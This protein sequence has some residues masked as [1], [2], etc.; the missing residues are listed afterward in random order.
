MPP[1]ACPYAMRDA[2]RNPRGRLLP[3]P[4]ACKK[5][6]PPKFP[7]WA[8]RVIGN[9]ETIKPT[10]IPPSDAGAASGGGSL[11]PRAR[12]AANLA[13]AAAAAAP[14]SPPMSYVGPA[15]SSAGLR[16]GSNVTELP[17][18][19]HGDA[20]PRPESLRFGG[21]ARGAA[22]AQQEEK[23]PLDRPSFHVAP[24]G[25]GWL[26]GAQCVSLPSV[27]FTF[28]DGGSTWDY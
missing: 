28:K 14:A 19:G 22:P 9:P 10:A 15:Q 7:R 8:C 5:P 12:S 13:T 23:T 1:G 24:R 4:L 25:G 3:P 17:D 6:D 16:G 18:D 2:I 26:N 20:Q 27:R 21:A 11:G